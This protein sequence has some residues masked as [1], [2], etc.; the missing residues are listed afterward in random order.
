VKETAQASSS[1]EAQQITK[2]ADLESGIEI[3]A[4]DFSVCSHSGIC[5]VGPLN[6]ELNKRQKIAIVGPS[7]AG[8]SSLLNGLLGFLPYQ[9]S[10]KINGVELKQLALPLWRK[11]LAWLGQEPQLFHG[12]VRENITLADP[13][14]TEDRIN[15]LL[16]KANLLDFIQQQPLGLE[17]TIG[18][19][20]TG[21]SVGQ[22]QRIALA[23]AIGQQAALFLLDEPTASL[24]RHSERAVLNGLQEAMLTSSC[25]MVT[26]RLEQLQKMD[27]ILVIDKGLIVQQGSFTQLNKMPGVFKQM[28]E[29][30]PIDSEPQGAQEVTL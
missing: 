10:L 18:E 22:A 14:M 5:L 8:K 13:D 30:Q 21:I 27:T 16:K 7:G 19:Q 3:I 25:L 4:R 29:E 17:T 11:N 23:R 28:Q 15:L 20:M 9:G 6:F 12:T 2:T 24:D 26:H 1:I